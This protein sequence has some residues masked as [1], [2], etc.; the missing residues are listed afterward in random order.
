MALQSDDGWSPTVRIGRRAG[1]LTLNFE[2]RLDPRQ[3]SSKAAKAGGLFRVGYGNSLTKIADVHI[4]LAIWLGAAGAERVNG[5]L[6][7]EERLGLLVDSE[8]VEREL[9]QNTAR[10]KRAKMKQAATVRSS[11]M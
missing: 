1:N 8:A 10:L 6:S 4:N 2:W 11:G 5:Q 7:F 3:E 9:R